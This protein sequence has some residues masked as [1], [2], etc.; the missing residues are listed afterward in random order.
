MRLFDRRTYSRI[1]TKSLWQGNLPRQGSRE[2]L[3]EMS[4]TRIAESG[5]TEIVKYL[6]RIT[7]L[8]IFNF[9]PPVRWGGAV[10]L[11]YC[12][13][14][15]K[16]NGTVERLLVTMAVPLVFVT[17]RACRVRFG[18]WGPWCE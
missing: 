7:I 5:C 3:L 14:V 11:D 6:T 17:P 18:P 1:Q 10:G 4:T 9:E 2:R 13:E 16:V 15:C 12:R 8:I